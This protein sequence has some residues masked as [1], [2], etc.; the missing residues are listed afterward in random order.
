MENNIEILFEKISELSEVPD[1]KVIR[2]VIKCLYYHI[3]L[4]LIKSQVVEIPFVG[5]LKIKHG[6]KPIPNP[7]DRK[8][9][10]K[11]E[12][13]AASFTLSPHLKDEINKA[14]EG[15]VPSEL[16]DETKKDFLEKIEEILS[17]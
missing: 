1:K 14:F 7:A 3:Y 16:L 6:I 13:T 10:V 11:K 8:S 5:T 2:K 9:T 12:Y 15:E 4:E 17:S